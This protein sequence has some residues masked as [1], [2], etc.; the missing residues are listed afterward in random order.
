MKTHLLIAVVSLVLVSLAFHPFD[1]WWLGWFGFVP[2]MAWHEAAPRRGTGRALML[3]YYFHLAYMLMWVGEIA[4]PLVWAIPLLGLPFV[5]AC[6][7]VSDRC[8]HGLGM[9]GLL[10][11]PLAIVSAELARDQVLGLTWS[12]IGYTQWRWLEGIQSAAIF[13]V[14]LLSWVV[15]TVNAAI[16]RWVIARWLRSERR[17]TPVDV[18]NGWL[19]AGAAVASLHVAGMV[20]LT[21]A[22]LEQGPVV[23][24]VQG[25]IPQ[26]MKLRSNRADA[27]DKQ[28]RIYLDQVAHRDPD[29][30]VFAETSFRRVD[31][32]GGP[33]GPPLETAL[34]MPLVTS[35]GPVMEGGRQV[36]WG[37]W[38]PRGRGQVSVL[39]YNRWR[40]VGGERE[41]SNVAGVVL[42]G[43]R[44]AEY[45]KRVLVPFGEYIPIRK[46]AFGHDWIVE[47][48]EAA[49]N[50]VP[51]LTPGDRCVA[52]PMETHGRRWTFGLNICYEVVFPGEFR[53]LMTEHAPDFIVEISNDGW[54]GTSNE[55]DLV[56][57]AARFRAI[58]CGRSFFRV[59]NTGISTSVDPYGRY[60][61]TVV[62]GG[63]TKVVQGALVDTVQI[64][65]GTTPWVF[66]GDL[67]AAIAPLTLSVLVIRARRR[68]GA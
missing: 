41:E 51:N 24:G 9:P 19:L 4:P 66:A 23:A 3:G 63:A 43:R 10:V 47:Q 28:R 15:L 7:W 42:D 13:R 26:V 64:A 68:R 45:A 36:T 5:W 32:D 22:D 57:V 44:I 67:W 65:R 53:S 6:A 37:G 21:W 60:R 61:Q 58:E 12:S 46:G 56:H 17:P 31:D 29:V 25:N 20:R 1:L 33:Y 48:I 52:V 55:L 54:Y 34:T 14:H 8:V 50:Y 18:R 30:L 49:A 39:G 35:E 11:Y 62:E 59:A 16:A 2:W 38:L 40:T 27:W